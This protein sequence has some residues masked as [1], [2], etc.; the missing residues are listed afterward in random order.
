M[1]FYVFE[2]NVPAATPQTN[3]VILEKEVIAPRLKVATVIIPNGHQGLAKLR[4]ES[5]EAPIIP[6]LGSDPPW[7]RGDGNMISVSPNYLLP[8][9]AWTLRFVGYNDD[10]TFDHAFIIHIDVQNE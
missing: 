2:F 6:T 1:A 4:I 5:R 8:G 7:I 3:P 9:P 10:A